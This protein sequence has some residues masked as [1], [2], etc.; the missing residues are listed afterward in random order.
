MMRGWMFA[1]LLLAATPALAAETTDQ[2][3][4]V[5][6][7]Q[8]SYLAYVPD[9]LK[10]P[11][12]VLILLHG[13][14][15]EP[16]QPAEHIIQLWRDKADREGIML[17]APRASHVEGWRPSRD[18]PDFIKAVIDQVSAHAA[19]DPHRVYLFG[20][21]GGA[22]YALTLAMLE[23][24]YFAAM[25]IHAGAWRHPDEFKVLAMGQRPIP[26]EILIG[27]QDEY[28][29]L[30]AVRETIQ[31]L[32]AKG[33]PA[34][35]QITPGQHHGFNEKTAPGIEDQAWDFLK[36]RTLKADPVF[37]DYGL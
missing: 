13:S 3:I 22:V 6:G 7:R 8:R 2:T 10:G 31:A 36:D 28:F 34:S 15:V 20:Q 14:S 32:V 33:F 35:L 19:V 25:S 26:M 23:S 11:A 12:P 37:Q 5:A 4:T 1:V 29:R 9:G 24:R 30:S 18:G 17:A 21:S 16:D 27:D